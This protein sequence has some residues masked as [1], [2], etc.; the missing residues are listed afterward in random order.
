MQF[1]PLHLLGKMSTVPGL[2]CGLFPSLSAGFELPLQ[3]CSSSYK[4]DFSVRFE[5]LAGS[6][7]TTLPVTGLYTTSLPAPLELCNTCTT[8]LA[9]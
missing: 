2:R 6:L 5:E 7:K 1:F 4:S 9:S 3:F 8:W